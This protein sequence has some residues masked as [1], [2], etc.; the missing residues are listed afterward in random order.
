M[1]APVHPDG[2]LPPVEALTVRLMLVVCVKLPLVPVTV[3]VAVP[4]V[5]VL[6]AVN[7]SVL[8]LVVLEGLNEAVTPEGRPD[9]DRFTLPLNPF[10]GLTVMVLAP[11]LPC[12]MVKLPGEADSEK[13]GG[14]FTV[15]LTVVECCNEALDRKSTRLNSS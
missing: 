1:S 2:R 12:T 15:R 10:I 7:V 13:S 3:T 8:L 6:P 9:A 4:V 11:L 14:G 5:A